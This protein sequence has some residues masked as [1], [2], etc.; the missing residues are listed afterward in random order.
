MG[1]PSRATSPTAA[2]GTTRLNTC[3]PATRVFWAR[4][5]T[6]WLNSPAGASGI[7]EGS[8]LPAQ[9]YVSR[10]CTTLTGLSASMQ[11]GADPPFTR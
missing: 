10:N 11:T 9:A 5:D 8:P 7:I 1:D 3:W 6:S 2:V 4:K